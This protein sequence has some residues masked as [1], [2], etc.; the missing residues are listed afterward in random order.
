[1]DHLHKKGTWKHV[2]AVH[3][4]LYYVTP[5]VQYASWKRFCSVLLVIVFLFSTVGCYHFCCRVSVRYVL[6]FPADNTR[7]IAA[8]LRLFQDART[9]FD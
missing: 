3:V 1:M 2:L 6:P 8:V 7:K 4:V 5:D 9:R